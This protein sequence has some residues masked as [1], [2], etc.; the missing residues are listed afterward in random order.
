MIST[1][2]GRCPAV[3]GEGGKPGMR[4]VNLQREQKVIKVNARC[5]QGAGG[6][7]VWWGK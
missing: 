4:Q 5:Q 1:G 3:G 7:K 2:R 6:R